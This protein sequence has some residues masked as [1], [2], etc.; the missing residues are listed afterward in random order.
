MYARPSDGVLESDRHELF[1]LLA[2]RARE[3]LSE[4][5]GFD[6]NTAMLGAALIAVAEVMRESVKQG[7]NLDK[8]IAFATRWLRVFL[9]QGAE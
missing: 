8:L 4:Q 1:R 5:S 9:E 6:W 7:G 2:Q 3:E